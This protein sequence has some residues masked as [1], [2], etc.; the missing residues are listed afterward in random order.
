MQRLQPLLREVQRKHKG[1]PTKVREE[2]AALYRE[3]G[4]S[5]FGGCLP[6]VLQL[7]ILF[8]LYQ[9]LS[10]ASSVI[11]YTAPQDQQASFEAFLAANPAIQ[12]SAKTSTRSPST[13]RAPSRRTSTS[14]CRSTAS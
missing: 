6:L 14:S 4:V 11:T 1:N 9:T 8:A 13:G 5:M 7:P 2:Q 12:L 3:H 10:R